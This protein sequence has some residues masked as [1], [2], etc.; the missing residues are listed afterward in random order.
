[1]LP[2][3]LA[4]CFKFMFD[5]RHLVGGAIAVDIHAQWKGIHFNGA[6]TDCHS[7]KIL[8]QPLDAQQTAQEMACVIICM[9]TNQIRAG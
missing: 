4:Q 5:F 3:L 9:K 1:M 8:F 6:I 2:N 7:P